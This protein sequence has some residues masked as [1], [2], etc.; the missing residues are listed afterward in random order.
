[1]RDAKGQ[2]IGAVLVFRD[3]TERKRTE[4]GLRFLADASVTLA[5]LV[6]YQSTLQK[7]AG[8]A[9]P[10][11]AD[12]CAVDILEPGPTASLEGFANHPLTFVRL[13]SVLLFK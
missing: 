1:M 9:V 10:Q 3:I 11:F 8:L 7:I 6:D 4:Q 13:F 12:W 2:T 5:S